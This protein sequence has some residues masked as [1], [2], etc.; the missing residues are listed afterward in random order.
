[1]P[2]RPQLKKKPM[3]LF[4]PEEVSSLSYEGQI[5][6]IV[7]GLIDVTGAAYEQFYSIHGFKALHESNPAGEQTL[8]AAPVILAKKKKY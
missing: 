4:V 2:S 5:V 6:E 7:D 8:E 3:K 1:M